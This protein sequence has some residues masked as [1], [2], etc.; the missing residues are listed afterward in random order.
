MEKFTEVAEQYAPM[1]SA[2]I[3]K[4]NIYS[5]YDA[6]RQLGTI[7]LWRAWEKHDPA[8]GHFAPFAYRSIQGAMKDELSRRRRGGHKVKDSELYLEEEEAVEW[9]VDDLP[10]WLEDASLTLKEKRLLEEM[11]I[12]G[13]SLSELRKHYGVTLSAMK[14]RRE[15]TLSK[16]RLAVPHPY[17]EGQK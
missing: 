6:F 5:D 16:I 7:A 13:Y 11:Y 17:K 14:K 1:I 8:I 4:L 10:D 2:I 9:P 3:R 15:R 12:E